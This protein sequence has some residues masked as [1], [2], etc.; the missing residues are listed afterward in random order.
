MVEVLVAGSLLG[1]GYLVNKDNER[2]LDNI[3]PTLKTNNKNKRT[4]YHSNI[5]QTSNIKEESL[6]KKNHK[7]SINAIDTNIIPNHFNDRIIIRSLK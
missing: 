7:K 6:V 4:L 1:L 5:V 2:P 3:T